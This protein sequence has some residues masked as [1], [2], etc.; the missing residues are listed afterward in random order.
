[1]ASDLLFCAY[2]KWAIDVYQ[3]IKKQYS[4]E[5]DFFLANV[6]KKVLGISSFRV[7]TKSN[8]KKLDLSKFLNCL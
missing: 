6:F 5:F 2:R 8:K 3:D 4:K 7:L 1:M